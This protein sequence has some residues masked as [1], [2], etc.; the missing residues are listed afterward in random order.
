MIHYPA[1]REHRGSSRAGAGCTS[2]NR[3]DTAI[4]QCRGRDGPV[5]VAHTTSEHAHLC[6]GIRAVKHPF[7]ARATLMHC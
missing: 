1:P 2:A 5:I 6:I 3:N 7:R 4:L